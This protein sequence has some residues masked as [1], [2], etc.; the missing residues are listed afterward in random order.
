MKSVN[1]EILREHRPELADLGAFAE[2]YVR[3]DPSSALVKLRS[4]AEH[5]V[6]GIYRQLGL[7]KP[8]QANLI[9]LLN[10]DSFKSVVPVVILDKLH[11]I[12]IHGNKAAHGRTII[13]ENALPLLREAYDLSRWLF[14]TFHGGKA[15]QCVAYQTPPVGGA[16]GETKAR[17]KREKK[18]ALERLA[19]QEARMQALLKELEGERQRAELVEKNAAELQFIQ[20][21]AQSAVDALQFDEATTRSRLIDGQ[22]LDAGWDVGADGRNTEEVTQEEEIQDQPTDSGL[23]YADYVLWDDNGK[24]LAVIE[25]KKT[26]KS[27]EIGRKQAVL[28]AD[29]L[30][31]KHSQ[32]PAIY[33]TNGIDIWLWD[34]VQGYPP[35]KLFGFY[36]K[37]S[38]QYLVNYQRVA[39]KDL[40]TFPPSAEIAGRLYQIEA[41]SRV[42]ERFTGKHR[43]AL[44]VQATGT[45]KTRV[46][47][48]IA[49]LLN[50]AGWTKRVLFLCDRRELRKQ[51]KNTFGNFL[52]GEPLTIVG[53]RTA[54][55][56]NQRIYLAT[57]PAMMRIFQTFDTG[58]YDLLIADES[59]RSIYNIYG[60]LFKYFDCL[61]VGLTATPVEFV[62]R[63]TYQ[64]FDC[65]EGLPTAYYPLERAVKEEFLVPF[66]VF[67]HTTQ[68]LRQG[69]KYAELT[70]E[71]IKQLE[72]DGEEPKL[73]EYEVESID[74]QV[75]NKD[76]NRAILRNL[77]ENGIREATNQH[78]GTSIIFARNHNHAMLMREL[79]DEMYP[80][81]GGKFCQVI[82]NYDPRAEQLIDDLKGD[83]NNDELTIAISVDMLDTGIDIPEIVNLVFAKPIKSKVKFWQ[84]I[85]RGTRLCPNL[86]GPGKDKQV[87][88]IFDHWGNFDFFDL[89]KPEA[90]P[91]PSKALMQQVFEARI[92]LAETALNLAETAVFDL[93]ADLIGADLASLPEESIPVREKWREKRTVSVPETLHAFTP[94]TVAVLRGDMAG[95]MQWVNI[96]GAAEAYQLDLLIVR[97]QTALLRK[98]GRLED[99]KDKLLD[100]VNALEMHLNQVRVKAETIRKVND[101]TFWVKATVEDLE[102]IRLDLRGIMHFHQRLRGPGTLPPKI[103]DIK[104]DAAKYETRQRSA[105]LQSIDM[106]AY[107]KLVEAALNDLFDTNP[108][109]K[110]IRA[111]EAVSE[112]DITALI[113]LILTQHPGVDLN[114]LQDFYPDTAMSLDFIIRSIIG[115]DPEAV[116]NRFTTFALKHPKLTAQQLRFLGLLQNHIARYG[117]I[118]I[119]RLYE[120]PFTVVDADGIDGV[121]PQDQADELV[122]IIRTFSPD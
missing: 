9:D 97:M 117:S 89:P 52:P 55:D 48:S 118:E 81:Y 79:F 23:G 19:A 84:M 21:S 65:E 75:F 38:M 96:H 35:R 83:G 111:G 50:R 54:G 10:N 76:T 66:E 2:Q 62:A 82:D 113:S 45:G 87:F 91:V 1:F 112:A 32:R 13:S 28:Y 108:T 71:Q 53:A 7:P 121:F 27:A 47:V 74:K 119:E 68:F 11:T 98:S 4:F 49:E 95:L 90:E 34:D 114:V 20:S 63:N 86:L 100:R 12:R 36:S 105:S 61:Q 31:K 92:D 3:P 26:A 102:E 8:Y 18:S 57:Y 43:K 39:K 5:M 37:D 56:R 64:L 14:I 51:A 33:Y 115:M 116:R 78:P 6:L 60:D 29:G 59:H 67:T 77:M 80:Q 93:A 73:L 42:T 44:V 25:A 120:D 88:R 22:L 85:G 104:E 99:Y 40:D 58:F 30:E 109:L 101:K 24:P 106:K 46:A 15:D 94:A 110:R 17:L 107:E 41:I 70:A 122:G 16:A 72:E 69:I 103:L